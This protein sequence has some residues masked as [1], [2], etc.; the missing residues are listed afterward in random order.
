M[1]LCRGVVFSAMQ[2]GT[3]PTSIP[4]L[5]TTTIPPYYARHDG[6]QSPSC[7]FINPVENLDMTDGELRMIRLERKKGKKKLV[8][9]RVLPPS[10]RVGAILPRF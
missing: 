10:P 1:T 6:L 3:A 2:A 7:P 9:L 5:G 8:K 4:P